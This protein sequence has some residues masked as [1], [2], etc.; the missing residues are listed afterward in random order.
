MGATRVSV[1]VR[2]PGDRSRSWSGRFLADTGATDSV[3]PESALRGI[4]IEPRTERRYA[5]ADGALRDF[6]IA[7]AELDVLGEIAGATVVFGADDAEPLL[8][9]AALESAGFEVDPV[10]QSLRKLPAGPLKPV[11]LAPGG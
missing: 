4:G 3:V 6:R 9:G 1:I 5:L 2:H 11:G 7:T 8:G 10:S